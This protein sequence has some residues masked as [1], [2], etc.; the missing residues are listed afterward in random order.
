MQKNYFVLVF[1]TI[2]SRL[3]GFFRDFCIAI[4]FGSSAVADALAIALRIPYFIRRLYGE[5]SLS[6]SLSVKYSLYHN[7]KYALSVELTKI[8]SIY[9]IP[10]ILLTF[11]LAKELVLL[12]APGLASMQ[13]SLNMAS[14]YV[15]YSIFYVFFA[16]LAANYMALSYSENKFFVAGF[17][18]SVFNLI[19]IFFSL[20]SMCLELE[21]HEKAILI[22]L[23][24]SLAGF[25]KLLML[26]AATKNPK[27][28]EELQKK[29]IKRISKQ[30]ASTLP[31]D[32][33]A[34]GFPQ[35]SFFVASFIA[36]FYGV[37]HISSLFYAERLIEFPLGLLGA[38]LAVA[39]ANKLSSL[40]KRYE[41]AKESKKIFLLC[42]AI[43]I[44]AAF[45]LFALSKQICSVL[46]GYGNFSSH[47]IELTSLALKAYSIALPAYALSRLL[48]SVVYNF[49]YRN[50]LWISTLIGFFTCVLSAFALMQVFDF[51]AAPLSAGLGIWAYTISLWLYSSKYLKFKIFKFTVLIFLAKLIVSSL[52]MYLF[53]DSIYSFFSNEF[54]ALFASILLGAMIYFLFASLF[55]VRKILK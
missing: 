23:G 2:L 26:R 50:I 13:E 48:L 44:P 8:L 46:F 38:S 20:C 7:Y 11:F 3:L 36:S 52:L 34:A 54:V 14:L 35:L 33:L 24:V 17:S 39:G 42:L 16:I 21:L 40:T 22:S 27:K 53:L 6:L 45:G 18:S 30:M 41:L 12:L 15:Q 31:L 10:C 32:T 55:G 4:I 5:G 9:L 51:L 19:I 37:G 28:N 47:S 1:A 49:K 29:T 25:A 43:N